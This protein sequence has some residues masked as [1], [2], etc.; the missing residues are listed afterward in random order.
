MHRRDKTNWSVF[1][2][3][4]KICRLLHQNTEILKPFA[5][6]DQLVLSRLCMQALR[7]LLLND[8]L[9]GERVSLETPRV[10]GRHLGTG[11]PLESS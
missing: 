4:F 10:R 2:K 3:D 8:V 1:V 7:N 6:T 11:D 5:K 9:V